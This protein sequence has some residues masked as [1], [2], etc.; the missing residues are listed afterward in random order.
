MSQAYGKLFAKVYNEKWSGFAN[1]VGPHILD[2]YTSK[3]ISKINKRLLD[4]CCGT[5]YLSLFFLKND[6]HVV[7]IDLSEYMLY[8]AKENT[9]EYIDH[10]KAK[11]IKTDASSFHLDD[12][13]GLA[14]STFD[15]LNHLGSKESLQSCFKS[16]FDVVVDEG[17]FIFDLNT[18]LG[19]K[20]W[21]S[22]S[23]S[24]S[25]NDIIINRG[26]FDEENNKAMIRITGFIPAGENL[27]QR[28]DEVVF[29][30]A[31]DMNEVKDMLHDSGW[32]EVYFARS[33]DL[34]TPIE[35]P[36]S[37]RRVFI[38][39]KKAKCRGKL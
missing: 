12:K 3:E 22:I 32:K 16:V 4:L 5:G 20:G 23:I 8:Y 17:Y 34:F 37:M 11:F 26:I 27:Y 2:F 29:N 13:F 9:K 39:A 38:V 33:E 31:Y 21:N 19:L 18:R 28:Y 6:Y 35:E 36:E 30:V 1:S 7:G 14:V 25:G 10:G 15:A 24:D